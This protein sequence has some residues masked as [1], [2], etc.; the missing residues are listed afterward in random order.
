MHI[1][2]LT[3]WIWLT[4]TGMYMHG[5]ELSHWEKFEKNWQYPF[6]TFVAQFWLVYMTLCECLF[7]K[8][9]LKLMDSLQ[10]H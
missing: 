3:L 6:I 10:L 1:H 8:K 5:F 7:S 9:L 4:N 2:V